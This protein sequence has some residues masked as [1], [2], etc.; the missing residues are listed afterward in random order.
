MLSSSAERPSRT[1]P[2]TGTRSPGRTRRVADPDLLDRD[3]DLVAVADDAR[4]RRLRGRI[5]ARIAAPVCPCARLQPAAQ[6]DS[7]T[8]TTDVSK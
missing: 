6:Q 3:V 5:S 2:S 8:M 1:M 4:R 7:A